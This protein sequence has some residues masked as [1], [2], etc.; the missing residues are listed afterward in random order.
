MEM[1][2]K[3]FRLIVVLGL[4]GGGLYLYRFDFDRKVELNTIETGLPG[5]G[6]GVEFTN[7]GLAE[8][9]DLIEDTRPTIPPPTV[10][11]GPEKA[12]VKQVP[13]PKAKLPKVQVFR[14]RKCQTCDRLEEFLDEQAIL[15]ERVLVETPKGKALFK[16]YKLIK[17]PMVR[18]GDKNYV[19]N[20]PLLLATV[21]KGYENPFKK[22]GR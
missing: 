12:V 5:V 18:I 16:K 10:G 13:K 17:V 7:K 14:S 22:F 1:P 19:G 8:V 20:D 6:E 3:V 4:L 15:F 21:L 2:K 9:N 11:I